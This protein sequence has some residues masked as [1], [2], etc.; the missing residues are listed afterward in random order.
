LELDQPR[1]VI[2]SNAF[3]IRDDLMISREI[4]EMIDELGV[5]EVIF[6]KKDGT[7]QRIGK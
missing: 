6:I 1:R 7:L 5:V 3:G 4:S 2:Y